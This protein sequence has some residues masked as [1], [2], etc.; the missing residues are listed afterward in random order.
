VFGA[1]F[2]EVPRDNMHVLQPLWDRFELQ[3]LTIH[4]VSVNVD[5]WHTLFRHQVRLCAVDICAR[6]SV[7]MLEAL[8]SDTSF[9]PALSRLLLRSSDVR[10]RKADKEGAIG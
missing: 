1:I 10:I 3:A 7:S 2:N 6:S 9:L 8:R 4:T 5:L